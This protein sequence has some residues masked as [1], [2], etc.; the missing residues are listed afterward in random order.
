[1]VNYHLHENGWTVILDNFDFSTATQEDAD[2][3]AHLLSTNLC[4][5]SKNREAISKMT[6]EDDVNFMHKVGELYEYSQDFLMGR[7]LTLAS[8]GPGKLIQ[9]VTASKNAEGHPGLFGQDDELDWHCNRPWHPDRKTFIW[10][11]SANGAGGSRTSINNTILAYQDL[12]KEDPEFVALLEE[13]QF[14]VVCGWRKGKEGGGH[15]VFY[16]YWHEHNEI[17]D[18]IQHENFAMPLIMTNET[19][20]KG[21][22]LP[23]LQSFTFLG[24]DESYA[25]PIMRRLWDYCLQEKYL[26]HH[27][28]ADKDEIMLMEQWLAVHKRWPYNHNPDRILYRIESDFGRCTW[29]Q[30][31]KESWKKFLHGIM[32]DNFK[33]IKRRQKEQQSV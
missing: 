23:Y 7:A 15:T 5:V 6:P 22:Y 2:Q 26:Y 13:K 25:R 12:Q 9:R 8:E 10:L 14:K 27:D 21:F 11:R 19:G 20:Q 28:W 3:I 16:D 17:E 4:V 29:F 33:Q 18:V 24:Y 32:L 30:D 1:M 31:Q